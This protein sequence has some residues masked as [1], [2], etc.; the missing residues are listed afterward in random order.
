MS[1][2][3]DEAAAA[4]GPDGMIFLKKMFEL[5]KTS[6]DPNAHSRPIAFDADMSKLHAS[7][8]PIVS[9]SNETYVLAE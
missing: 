9:G 7:I 6:A 4:F 5:T 8:T 3:C 1:S 2:L